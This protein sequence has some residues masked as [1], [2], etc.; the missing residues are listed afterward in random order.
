[1][2]RGS[3]TPQ[4]AAEY[5]TL[6]NLG[7]HLEMF[8]V[9]L[10]HGSGRGSMKREKQKHLLQRIGEN[11]YVFC[12]I[13]GILLNTG[14]EL[15][16]R[17]SFWNV[18]YY[19][20]DRPL[21]FLY[22]SLVIAF[23][24]SFA[25]I[26]RR[27][28]FAF[29]LLSIVWLVLGVI[30]SIILVFRTTPFTASDMLLLES[31]Y[32]VMGSY[33]DKMQMVLL[34]VGAVL[35]F[36]LIV[37]VFRKAPKRVE[38][39]S[40]RNVAFYI[41]GLFLLT[42]FATRAGIQTGLLADSFGNIGNAYM[43]Y[44][45][46]YCFGNSLLNTGIDKPV[47]YSSQIVDKLVQE[48]QQ[49][50]QHSSYPNL[51][52]EEDKVLPNFIFL[53]LESFFDPTYLKGVSFSENPLPNFSAM[54]EKYS[55]GYLNVPSVGAG[56]AN[57]EFEVITGMNLDFF[58]PG[59]YPY[60]TIL[61][62]TT[63]ESIAYNLREEGYYSRVLHNNDGTFYERN[64]IFPML[65]F[66]GFTSLEYM[67]A[68]F[69]EYTCVGWAKDRI[70]TGEIKKA[71]KSTAGKDV[72]Y[73]ISVQGHGSYPAEKSEPLW[74]QVEADSNF[75][76]AHGDERARLEYYVNQLYEMDQFLGELTKFL[77]D[78][79]EPS[80]LVMYGDHLPGF[81]WKEEDLING[82]LFQTEYI[83]WDNYNLP[84]KDK[85]LEAYQLSSY[86]MGQAGL[87]NGI[88]TK[89]HQ[90]FAEKENYQEGLKLLQYDMLYG[91]REVYNGEMPYQP[92]KLVMGTEPITVSGVIVEEEAV[93]ILGSHFT[94]Y[95]HVQING[96]E[97]EAEYISSQE[98]KIGKEL[99]DGDQIIVYQAGK[100]AVSLSH[101]EEY[102]Y[103]TR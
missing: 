37:V 27:R 23:T 69:L 24:V 93:R 56:T 1:M 19:F 41:G 48:V 78:F 34:A 98:L 59:E 47:D 70:L 100:D 91:D 46:P 29:S 90:A 18:F 28:V 6:L 87:Y 51:I 96:N 77:S 54:R 3:N 30:N 49:P 26:T 67:D 94:N 10:E 89:Y 42:D 65:G 62:E 39:I 80:I 25:L 99:K 84:K 64:Q 81:D 36:V 57:T 53:Q 45:F 97:I 21:I 14:V 74:I 32:A 33:M 76:E 66:D 52:K 43:E 88:L 11:P 79:P 12:M 40:Y 9:V 68:D 38:R 60:K 2:S 73:V 75:S 20:M 61:K 72:L 86:V 8:I 4:L 63:C 58:G 7:K 44:G 83:I 13:L 92:S 15:L 103:Y 50:I 16:S 95:S 17:K 102:I 5:L 55:S 85:N 22:N 101:T 35:L 71:L 82:D 31:A